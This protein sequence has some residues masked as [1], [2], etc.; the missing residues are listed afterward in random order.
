M[1]SILMPLI[2]TIK[3]PLNFLFKDKFNNSV[4]SK[5]QK[6]FHFMFEFKRKNYVQKNSTLNQIIWGEY[7]FCDVNIQ[8]REYLFWILFGQCF[9]AWCPL[10]GHTYVNKTSAFSLFKYVWPFNRH[11]TWN[12]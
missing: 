7:L 11:Q 8:W 1:A 6:V 3:L 12:G 5:K 2:A 10:D 4:D 9:S